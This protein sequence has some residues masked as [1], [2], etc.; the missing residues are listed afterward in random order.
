MSVCV[1]FGSGFDIML[2]CVHFGLVL[3]NDVCFGL[4][5]MNECALET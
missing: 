1:C 2:E 3:I 5:L 4:V